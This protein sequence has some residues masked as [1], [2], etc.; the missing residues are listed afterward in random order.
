MFCSVHDH[1][2]CDCPIVT[3]YINKHWV[4]CNGKGKIWST[5]P[6]HESNFVE[7]HFLEGPD[8]YVFSVD[9]DINRDPDSSTSDNHRVLE[10]FR[11][12]ADSIQAQIDKL[13]GAQVRY[14]EGK[15]KV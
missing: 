6:A 14:R 5:G 15:E 3:E 8:E 10:D 11:A 9:V 13:R 4:I 12:Q 2:V 1:Y 7:T